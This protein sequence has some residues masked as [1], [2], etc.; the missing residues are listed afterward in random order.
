M[1][2]QNSEKDNKNSGTEG[3]KTG[4]VQS[5]DRAFDILESLSFN[6]SGKRLTDLSEE[7]GLHKSTV[8]RI[9]NAMQ[10]RG[11]VE[12]GEKKYK[13]GIG[14]I[15]LS[16]QLLNS[17]ELKTEAEPFLR[18]LSNETG[19]TVF[20]AIREGSEVVYIDKVEQF[21][22]LRRYSIIGN[23]VPIYCT[24]LGRSLLF[25]DSDEMLKSLFGRINLEKLT[26]K[27]VVDQNELIRRVKSFRRRGW[28]EDF[29]E[30]QTGVRCVGAPVYDY[31]KRIAAAISTAWSVKKTDV[32]SDDIGQLVKE[33]AD[34][35]SRRLGWI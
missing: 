35:V 23:R 9:L 10:D 2:K 25:D 3:V 31:R 22:S 19:Q 21:N 30:H 18:H 14:F 20:L 5:I 1:A 11:Y 33:T 12:Q 26:P 24:S 32:I 15:H 6:R 4:T 13:L 28:A 16:S 34:A 29:E 8:H 27:T 7:L 17:I